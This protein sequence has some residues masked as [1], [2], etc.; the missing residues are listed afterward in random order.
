MNISNFFNANLNRRDFLKKTGQLALAVGGGLTLSSLLNG[1]ATVGFESRED[2]ANIK[3]DANPAIPVPKDGCYLG[4]HYD[5]VPFSYG[6]EY[7]S[8]Y[9]PSQEESILEFHSRTYGKQVAA[10][11]FSDKIIGKS[12]YFPIDICKVMS[13]QGV[14]PIIRWHPHTPDFRR[15]VQGEHDD[16]L[17][18]FSEG[19]AAY[20]EPFFFVP[21]P[22]VN[23]GSNWSDVHS[24]AKSYGAGFQEAWRRMHE[25]F[26]AAGANKNT[27][28][29]LHL[30]GFGDKKSYKKYDIDDQYV[31]W[32]GFTVYNFDRQHLYHS[33]SERMNEGYLWSRRN[34]PTK[35]ISV[36]EM[37]SSN[38]SRQGRWIKNAYK[39]IKNM[40]RIKLAVYAEYNFGPQQNPYDSTKITGKADLTY[41]EAISDPYF[42][43]A[44]EM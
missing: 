6:P 42:I 3:W 39:T 37:G 13:K 24:Y 18:E 27:V 21:F 12:G 23:I 17:K 31:D 29:G 22:E 25:I 16:I 5:I 40:P 30:L 36:W 11:S 4:W 19:A 14:I 1:C 2:I 41:K 43:G 7:L 10:H 32:I 44:R 20:Q 15:V 35:P 33:F 28:W 38:T 8:T 34:H 26:S 9:G